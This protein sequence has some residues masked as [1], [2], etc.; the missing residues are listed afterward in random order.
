MPDLSH[1]IVTAWPVPRSGPSLVVPH[2]TV[3]DCA[4]GPS[5]DRALPHSSSTLAHAS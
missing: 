1:M 4:L 3:V 5:P 2:V